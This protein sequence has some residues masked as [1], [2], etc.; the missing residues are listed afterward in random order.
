MG[1]VIR[2][3][4]QC[5]DDDFFYLLVGDRQFTSRARLISQ[6][7]QAHVNKPL[8]PLPDRYLVALEKCRG[9][10]IVAAF[11]AGQDDIGAQRQGLR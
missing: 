5:I 10:L 9:F 3:S 6:P 7:V 2:R 11:R 4:L 8:A 1:R